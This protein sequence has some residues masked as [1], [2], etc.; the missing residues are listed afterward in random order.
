MAEV[1][2]RITLLLDYLRNDLEIKLVLNTHRPKYVEETLRVLG[3]PEEQCIYV[4][5]DY[6]YSANKLYFATP[7]YSGCPSRDGIDRVSNSLVGGFQNLGI[8]ISEERDKIVFIRRKGVGIRNILNFEE[9]VESFIKKY[10]EFSDEIVVFDGSEGL[11]RTIEIFREAKLVVGA[12][13]AGLVNV[14]FCLPGTKV[15]EFLPEKDINLCF[16]HQCSAA[17]LDHRF[18]LVPNKGHLDSFSC[19]INNF[20]YVLDR[21]QI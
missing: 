5:N 10:P 3:I 1:L 18:I 13:G 7:T 19:S 2:P 16:W 15:I 20:M 17:K 6:V 4:N 11:R 21:I 8:N 14:M 9:L 12:H